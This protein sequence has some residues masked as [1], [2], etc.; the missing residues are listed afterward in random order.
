MDTLK[1]SVSCVRDFKVHF[2]F[3]FIIALEFPRKKTGPVTFG[4]MSHLLAVDVEV[5][6]GG[7]VLDLHGEDDLLPLDHVHK[8]LH[9]PHEAIGVWGRQCRGR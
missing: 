4:C 5:D 8:L 6:R 1:F 3:Y 2:F 9:R 7:G